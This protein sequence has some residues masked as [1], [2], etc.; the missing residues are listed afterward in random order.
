MRLWTLSALL[1]SGLVFTCIR[2]ASAASTSS[3]P[4]RPELASPYQLYELELSPFSPA[5]NQPAGV[6]LH[7]SINGGRPLRMVLDSGAGFVVVSAKVGRALGLSS[8]SEMDLVGLGTRPAK[9]GIA[10]KVEVGNVSFRN[11]RVAMVQGKVIEGADGVIPLAMFSDFLIRLDLPGRTLALIPYAGEP[12]P[13]V[14]S[15]RADGETGFLLVGALLNRTY[16]GY[17]VLDTGA[18]CSGVSREM[19]GALNNSRPLGSLPIGAATGAATG[20]LLPGAVH[21]EIAGQDL[22][23]NEIVALDLLN[24]SR[25]CGMEV[26]GVIGF[27]VLRPY[28]L[29]VDYRNRSVRIDSKRPASPRQRD[30]SH[31]EAPSAQLAFR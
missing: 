11:C 10:E 12:R 14:S 22:V 2:V 6:L 9:M 30:R 1:A 27:P 18:F 16:H 20:Q 8:G 3:L 4:V 15:L 31:P 5:P 29:S 19:A 13:E 23:P 28:V 7:V 25:H 26:V 17:V 24:L 21:F